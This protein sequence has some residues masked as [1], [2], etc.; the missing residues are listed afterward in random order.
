MGTFEKVHA[1]RITGSLTLYDRLMALPRWLRT[2]YYHR[3]GC[4]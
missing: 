2:D 4:G 1:S 3:S